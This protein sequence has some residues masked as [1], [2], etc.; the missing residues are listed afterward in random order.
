LTRVDHAWA[1]GFWEADGSIYLRRTPNSEF[2][3]PYITASQTDDR[4]PLDK[5]VELYGGRVEGPFGTAY[6]NTHWRWSMS[7]TKEVRRFIRQVHP[8]ITIERKKRKLKIAYRLGFY[9]IGKDSRSFS[10]QRERLEL[11]EEFRTV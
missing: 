10:R 7:N 2:H 11:E 6:G 9:I 4:A 5:L 8:Y 3:R 1:A